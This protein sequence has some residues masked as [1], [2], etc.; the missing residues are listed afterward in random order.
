[1]SNK[2]WAHFFF[3][4]SDI[5]SKLTSFVSEVNVVALK[6]RI[7]LDNCDGTPKGDVTS[8]LEEY[9]SQDDTEVAL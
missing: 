9:P 8:S 2:P 7:L 6:C 4:M 5:K 3:L 1:M